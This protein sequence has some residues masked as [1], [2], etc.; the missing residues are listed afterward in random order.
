MPAVFLGFRP[1]MRH[2]MWPFSKPIIW[3][4]IL[5]IPFIIIFLGIS[6]IIVHFALDLFMDGIVLSNFDGFGVAGHKAKLD[7]RYVAV[8]VMLFALLN[9]PIMWFQALFFA[10]GYAQLTEFYRQ[11]RAVTANLN[12]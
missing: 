8:Y 10:E 6:E 12:S 9:V 2:Q 5:F 3:K 7:P 11:K 1:S 4:F